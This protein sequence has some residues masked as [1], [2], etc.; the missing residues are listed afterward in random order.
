MTESCHPQTT[1]LLID[2]EVDVLDGLTTILTAAGYRIYAAASAEAALRSISEIEADLIVCDIN[3]GG[4]S[5]LTLCEQLK[6]TIGTRSVPILFLSGAQIPDVIRRAHAAGGS[7]YL[8]KPFDPQVLL[9][10]VDKALWMPHVTA[11][12]MERV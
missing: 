6:R 9:E 7:Y 5:G 8:R 1:I 4:Q 11:A 3:L 10:L 2:D 12:H